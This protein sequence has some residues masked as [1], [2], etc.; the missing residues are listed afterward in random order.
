M[1]L[2][3]GEDFVSI[4]LSLTYSMEIF[5]ILSARNLFVILA[6]AFQDFHVLNSLCDNPDARKMMKERV[7]Y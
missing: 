2:S 1:S 6:K 5:L 3:P 4:S 7:D